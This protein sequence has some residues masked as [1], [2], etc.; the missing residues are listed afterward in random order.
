MKYVFTALVLGLCL[1]G[2]ARNSIRARAAKDLNC[3]IEEVTTED[4]G[5]GGVRAYGCGDSV[6]YLCT[7]TYPYGSLVCQR[8]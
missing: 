4:L 1:V 5:A 8:Q 3:P 2:C 6:E 7:T